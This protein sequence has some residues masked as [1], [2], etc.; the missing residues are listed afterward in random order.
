[1]DALALGML[2]GG[3]LLVKPAPAAACIGA[4]FY[5]CKS[6]WLD[7]LFYPCLEQNCVGLPQGVYAD[8][9]HECWQAYRDASASDCGN[10][11]I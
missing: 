8:C 7:V 4:D 2:V 10:C 9:R 11:R 1:M 3:L 6:N 5:E